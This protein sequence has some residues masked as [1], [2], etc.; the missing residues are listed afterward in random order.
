MNLGK[1]VIEQYKS[2]IEKKQDK[3]NTLMSEKF[4]FY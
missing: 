3:I 1:V 4:L 2:N